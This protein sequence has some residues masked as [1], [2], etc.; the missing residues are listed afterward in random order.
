ML[1]EVKSPQRKV[2]VLHAIVNGTGTAAITSGSKSFTLTDNGTGSYK[3]VPN[4]IG[5]RLLSVFVQPVADAG[6]LIATLHTD[7][8]AAAIEVRL[9]DGTDGTTAKDGIFHIAAWY[10]DDADEQ[11]G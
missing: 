1:R 2:R 9:W 4:N 3:L 6:D 11:N 7:T 5:S 8:A 10:S